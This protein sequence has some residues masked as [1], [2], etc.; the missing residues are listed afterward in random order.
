MDQNSLKL[1]DFVDLVTNQV[2]WDNVSQIP[3]FIQLKGKGYHSQY[4]REGDTWQHTVNTVNAVYALDEYHFLPPQEQCM[5]VVAALFHD[6][7]KSVAN[8][9]KPNGDYRAINHDRIGE[10]KA[11]YMLWDESFPIRETICGLI[12]NHMVRLKLNNPDTLERRIK[13]TSMVTNIK[14]LYLLS[15]CDVLGSDSIDKEER[16]AQAELIKTEAM[17]YQ[18][19]GRPMQFMNDDEKFNYFNGATTGG[20]M[21]KGRIEVH[22]MCGVAGAGKSKYIIDNLQHLPVISRDRV[23]EELGYVAAGGKF[24]GTNE[25]EQNVTDIIVE[26]IRK[27]GE[28]K[29]SFVYDGMNIKKKYIDS[30]KQL[31]LPYNPVIKVYYIETTKANILERRKDQIDE[32]I[33]L[34]ML[35][36]VEIPQL[37]DVHQLN[38]LRN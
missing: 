20:C 27:F 5:L 2:I 35:Q 6:I 16:L 37:T 9:L 33:I 14:L 8:E 10:L 32:G 34:D 31:V 19:F 38:Y 28:N 13:K 36:R 15:K 18:C 24:L 1:T 17:K 12:R 29:T 22:I 26:Q 30:I 3:E 4:H 11:R 25:Q 21:C 23:R 7:G